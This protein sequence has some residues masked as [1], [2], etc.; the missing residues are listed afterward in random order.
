MLS[1]WLVPLA[2][3]SIG[4][5][6]KVIVDGDPGGTGGGGATSTG[7]STGS[8]AAGGWQVEMGICGGGHTNDDFNMHT[9]SPQGTKIGCPDTGMTGDAS[10]DGVVMSAG[11]TGLTVTLCPPGTACDPGEIFVGYYAPGLTP[12]IP[13]GTF[14]H[15]E[16]S[17]AP[18]SFGV[19][20]TL[21]IKNLPNFGGVPN[22]ITQDSGLW[23]AGAEGTLGTFPGSPF[24][25][26]PGTSC[27]T[28]PDGTEDRTLLLTVPKGGG[29][30][31]YVIDIPMGAG[32][33]GPGPSGEDWFARN[34]RSYRAP[35]TPDSAA[36]MDFAYWITRAF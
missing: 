19:S 29:G 34:L 7:T 5:G 16:A 22:L 13:N 3:V 12:N 33:S 8:T 21:L 27:G 30:A 6:G 10:F 14:V 11:N 26:A 28:E 9:Q 15:V 35:M 17:S 2:L 23:L 18:A 24:Q 36:E 25:V 32:A 31:P 20:C 4:C 1:R